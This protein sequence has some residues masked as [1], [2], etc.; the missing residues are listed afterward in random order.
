MLSVETHF[1]LPA[2]ETIPANKMKAAIEKIQ[3]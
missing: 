1:E 3:S 2:I